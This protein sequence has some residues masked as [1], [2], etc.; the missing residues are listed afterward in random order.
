MKKNCRW[1][2]VLGLVFL[3]A[4]PVYGN[5][6]K[7][8]A[9][10]FKK[11]IEDC[12]DKDGEEL[13]KCAD[14]KYKDLYGC[15]DDKGEYKDEDRGEKKFKKVYRG[16]YKRVEKALNVCLRYTDDEK[17]DCLNGTY[18]ASLKDLNKDVKKYFAK[19][20]GGGKDTDVDKEVG[21]CEGNLKKKALGCNEKDGDKKYKCL[22]K[23]YDIFYKCVVKDVKFKNKKK[24]EKKFKK[25]YNGFLDRVE[26][27]VKVCQRYTSG[28]MKK[29]LTATHKAAIKD[30]KRDLKKFVD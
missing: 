7:V 6:L 1:I 2:W 26:D 13:V 16:F 29:C 24:G 3:M 17:D 30:F 9:K 27:A 19:K 18:K 14:I 12:N 5:P 4:S 10:T 15:L 22:K 23:H 25:V 20:K 8:C 11:T 21:D 28:K